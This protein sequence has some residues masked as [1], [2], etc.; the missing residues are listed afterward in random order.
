MLLSARPLQLRLKV[1]D[2]VIQPARVRGASDPRNPLNIGAAARGHEQIWL[3]TNMRFVKAWEVSFARPPLAV[4]APDL[5]AMPC[6]HP[7]LAEGVAGAN[8]SVGTHRRAQSRLQHTR[9]S[10]GAGDGM[11][12]KLVRKDTCGPCSF[13]SEKRGLPMPP[14]PIQQC[15][16]HD[17]SHSRRECLHDM[18]KAWRYAFTTLAREN[19]SHTVQKTVTA[20]MLL[21]VQTIGNAGTELLIEV[22]RASGYI[23]EKPPKKR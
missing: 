17:P 1:C 22:L 9:P 20:A 2:I 14:P 3:F 21:G 19:E 12:H 11:I 13:G 16:A 4:G 23:Y 7:S 8:F 6:E 18:G 15:I 10:V 5:R